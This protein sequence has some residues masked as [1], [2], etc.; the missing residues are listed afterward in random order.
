MITDEQRRELDAMDLSQPEALAINP[1]PHWTDWKVKCEET[2]L[3]LSIAHSRIRELR[4]CLESQQAESHNAELDI[5]RVLRA[6]PTEC[7]K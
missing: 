5:I 1:E 3:K 4:A 6:N 2:E 7:E